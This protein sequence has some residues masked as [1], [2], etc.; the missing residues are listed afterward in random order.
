MIA[1]FGQRLVELHLLAS[2]E[3]D[4]PLTKF[5]GAGDNRVEEVRYDSQKQLISINPFQYFAPIS[6]DV[7]EFEIGG[8]QVCQKWLKD[9]K[10]RQLAFDD[11]TTYCWIMT[12]LYKTKEIQQKIDQQ[13]AAVEERTI[14]FA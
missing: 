6:Q 7:W 14:E 2:P 1:G 12:A 8:Y 11:I 9:R 4:P 10:G 5:E 13:F 3:L